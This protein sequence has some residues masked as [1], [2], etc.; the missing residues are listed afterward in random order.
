MVGIYDQHG[1]IKIHSQISAL[2]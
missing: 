1:L 2:T